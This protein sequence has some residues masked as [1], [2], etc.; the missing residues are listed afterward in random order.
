M[1]NHDGNVYSPVDGKITNIFPTLHAIGLE[2]T[3]G[4]QILIHM[5]IDT[6]TLEGQP[7]TV[8]V[9]TGQQELLACMDVEKVREAGKE[10]MIIVV[11]LE[12]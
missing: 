10:D 2:D 12:N 1:K 6:V 9:K 4:Q 7:F 3:N 8:N 11:L 5:G